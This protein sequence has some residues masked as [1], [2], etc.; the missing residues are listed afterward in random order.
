MFPGA[1]ITIWSQQSGTEP[2]SILN[3]GYDA[4]DQ[5]VSATVTNG[6]ALVSA[7]SYTHD[8]SGNRLTELAGGATNTATY[9]ALNQISTTAGLGAARTNE[10]DAEDRLAAVT[11]GNSSGLHPGQA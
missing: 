6:G 9:N 3:L 8:P 7:F 5:V 10:W 1:R 11:I 2:P 4:A